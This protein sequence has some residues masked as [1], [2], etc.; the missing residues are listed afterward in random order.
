MEVEEVLC[1]RILAN[2]D[3][4]MNASYN[5]ELTQDPNAAQ[6]RPVRLQ[7]KYNRNGAQLWRFEVGEYT[8]LFFSRF[9]SHNFCCLVRLL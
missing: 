8:S 5:M 2:S 7:R 9:A 1:H 4:D 6:T 3:T